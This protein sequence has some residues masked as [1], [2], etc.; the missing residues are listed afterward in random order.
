[1]K[2]LAK[3]CILLVVQN[4]A[5]NIKR[6]LVLWSSVSI[7][8]WHNL[9]SRIFSKIG[10]VTVSA[11]MFG[12][13]EFFEFANWAWEQDSKTKRNYVFIDEKYFPIEKG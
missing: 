1:M 4:C 7:Y 3:V 5:P 11:E 12:F 9:I 13:D 6:P 10:W 2:D 8:N